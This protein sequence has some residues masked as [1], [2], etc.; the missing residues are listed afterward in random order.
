MK[1]NEMLQNKKRQFQK[2]VKQGG[3]TLIEMMVVMVIL[4]I[5]YKLIAPSIIGSTD[6]ATAL[7]L[8]DAA[9]KIATNLSMVSQQCGTSTTVTGNVL[10]AAGKTLSD[11]LF[12]GSANVAAAYT[13]CYTQSRVLPLAEI[14]AATATAGVYA[15]AGFNVSL[16]GG[17]TAPLG[18]TFAGVP[19]ALVLIV[20]Q[21]YTPTLTALA[22][23]D[24]TSPVVRY[25][26][27]T[28]GARDITI[29]KQI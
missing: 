3:F 19:D 24:S 2:A 7:Q 27:A 8:P 9:G 18:I 12:G 29:L 5:L 4:G 26:T 22:A 21:K 1:L 25:G 16:A 15:V 10:P 13:N 28:A 23:S 17:G 6:G 14:G 11:V 20:A